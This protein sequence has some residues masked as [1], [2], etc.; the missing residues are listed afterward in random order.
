[1]NAFFFCECELPSV[2][3][4]P[5][6]SIVCLLVMHL[7][8]FAIYFAWITFLIITT[9]ASWHFRLLHT[10]I[11]CGR[12]VCR[13]LE[14]KISYIFSRKSHCAKSPCRRFVG[15]HL[16]RNNNWL[17]FKLSKFKVWY[18]WWA[19]SG[20]IFHRGCQRRSSFLN[21]MILNSLLIEVNICSTKKSDQYI[22]HE[23]ARVR[24]VQ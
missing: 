21:N 24:F 15:Y 23:I 19:P 2:W 12:K 20:L 3:Y 18:Q 8:L 16:K 17:I 10:H 9:E 14:W 5:L 22:H 11:I 13:Q 1:M 4:I 7:R 6:F